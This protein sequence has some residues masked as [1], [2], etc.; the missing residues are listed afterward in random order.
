MF[1]V[2]SLKILK[3]N[4]YCRKESFESQLKIQIAIT[5]IQHSFPDFMTLWEMDIWNIL[6]NFQEKMRR[7]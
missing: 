2:I 7:K 1:S 3:I 6:R 5:E 4:P